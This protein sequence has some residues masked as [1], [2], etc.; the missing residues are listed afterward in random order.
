MYSR[1]IENTFS[2][3]NIWKT[4]LLGVN[5]IILPMDISKLN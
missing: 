3:H 2:E 5:N 1:Y 4:I